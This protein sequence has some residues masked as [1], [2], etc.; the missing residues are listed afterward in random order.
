MSDEW[1]VCTQSGGYPGWPGQGG[2]PNPYVTF[3]SALS[4]FIGRRVRVVTDCRT[5]TGRLIE[6]GFDFVRLRRQDRI[7]FIRSSR[8]C[9]VEVPNVLY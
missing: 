7:I 5:F 2:W 1:S 3:A 9:A 8:I 6:V 4:G